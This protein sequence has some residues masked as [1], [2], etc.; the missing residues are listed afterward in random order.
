M[1]YL[2]E[3]RKFVADNFNSTEV[4]DVQS[5]EKFTQLNNLIDKADNDY[6]KVVSANAELSKTLT[7][8]AL[9]TA[10]PVKE[11]T[12]TENAPIE[13][14]VFDFDDGNFDA[15]LNKFLEGKN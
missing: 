15:A 3:L 10:V 12:P 4:K 2:Q 7:D 5:I 11:N 9:H 13:T 1:S 6:S 8:Y 14:K